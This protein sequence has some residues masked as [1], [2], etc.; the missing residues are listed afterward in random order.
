MFDKEYLSSYCGSI[1]LGN[2]MYTEIYR[3]S[4]P[5]HLRYATAL[6]IRVTARRYAHSHSFIC[7]HVIIRVVD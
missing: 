2:I 7:S 4:A 6:G 3:V 1:I 5:V